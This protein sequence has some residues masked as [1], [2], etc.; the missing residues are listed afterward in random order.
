MPGLEP[1]GNL[2]ERFDSL[3]KSL[4]EMFP[5]GEEAEDPK[6]IWL[7]KEWVFARMVTILKLVEDQEHHKCD[8]Y[9]M[10]TALMEAIDSA[11]KRAED[12]SKLI[13]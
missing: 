6:R 3:R 12:L 8:S 1:T 9:I 7:I 10:D 5:Q 11:I 4:E 13:K 2:R